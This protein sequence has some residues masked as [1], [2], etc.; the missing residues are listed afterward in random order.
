FIGL[1]VIGDHAL[2]QLFGGIVLGFSFGHF[3]VLDF[4]HPAFVSL[5]Q[6]FLVGHAELGF[7]ARFFFGRLDIAGE[8][9]AGRRDR[10]G[11]CD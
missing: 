7:R 9:E 1:A 5:F 6:E 10:R 4:G 3:R 11:E 2:G 8:A